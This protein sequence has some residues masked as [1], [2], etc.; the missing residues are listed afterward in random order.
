MNDR[1]V[2]HV[3]LH[4]RSPLAFMRHGATQPNLDGLRCGG[5]LDVPLTPIGREQVRTLATRLRAAELPF[6]VI[7]TSDLQRTRASAEIL[8]GTLGGLPVIEITGFRERALGRWNGQPAAAT[9]AALLRGDTP[10]GGESRDEFAARVSRAVVNLRQAVS[11]KRLPLLVG[12]RGIARVLR[13]QHP[14]FHDN[15]S[16]SPSG[17]AH[18]PARNAELLWFDLGVVHACNERLVPDEALT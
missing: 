16:T 17:I 3:A 10:E 14:A 12:S 13:T 11:G 5:D 2:T 1:T 15:G 8:A 6:D 7:V 9:E 4:L 18:V